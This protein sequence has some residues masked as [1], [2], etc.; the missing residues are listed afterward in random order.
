MNGG[1]KFPL[2]LVFSDYDILG[3]AKKRIS[4]QSSKTFT[5]IREFKPLKSLKTKQPHQTNENHKC[6]Y[7]IRSLLQDGEEL[8]APDVGLD[9]YSSLRGGWRGWIAYFRM[10]G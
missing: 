4:I 7:K 8:M 9:A 1:Q 2:A 10:E 3:S 6:F 5:L